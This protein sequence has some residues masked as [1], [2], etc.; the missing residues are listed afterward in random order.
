MSNDPNA[1]P[2]RFCGEC[3]HCREILW[4]EYWR[5]QPYMFACYKDDDV[6]ALRLV[7]EDME[8]CRD[9]RA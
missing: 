5:G 3:E 8:A 9:W 2:Q 7:T 6:D 4:R 1:E